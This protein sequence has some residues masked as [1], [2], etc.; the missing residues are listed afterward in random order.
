MHEDILARMA[1]AVGVEPTAL[2]EPWPPRSI[3][4]PNAPASGAATY[5]RK[6]VMP[7][8]LPMEERPF[9]PPEAYL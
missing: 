2:D 1:L 4:Y 9:A 3:G 5:Y 7:D 8:P 6:A